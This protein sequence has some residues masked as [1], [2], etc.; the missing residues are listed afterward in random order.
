MIRIAVQKLDTLVFRYIGFKSA[1]YV[2]PDSLYT[3]RY[4]I[5]QILTR[6]EILLP[7]TVVYPWPSKEHLRRVPGNGC[8]R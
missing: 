8:H 6:D 7:Q 4:T 1:E 5:F 2:V 3:D